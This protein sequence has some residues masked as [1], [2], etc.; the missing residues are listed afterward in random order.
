[1]TARISSSDILRNLISFP[2]FGCVARLG[3]KMGR[4]IVLQDPCG[5]WGVFDTIFDLPAEIGGRLMV[6]LSLDDAKACA[7]SANEEYLRARP[8]GM[9]TLRR[10]LNESA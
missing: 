9:A 7:A 1:M 10:L 6:G 2:E 4:F 3:E 5:T 8:I